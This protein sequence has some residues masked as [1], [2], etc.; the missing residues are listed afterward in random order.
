M[1]SAHIWNKMCHLSL[2]V[3][4]HCPTENCEVDFNFLCIF[5]KKKYRVF[6]QASHIEEVIYEHW[7]CE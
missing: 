4:P 3:L 6:E 1:I 5:A 2:T 7:V